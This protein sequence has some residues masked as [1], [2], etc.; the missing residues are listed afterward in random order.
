M[1]G[2]ITSTAGETQG[3][4]LTKFPLSTLQNLIQLALAVDVGVSKGRDCDLLL[5][6]TQISG[7]FVLLSGSMY[8]TFC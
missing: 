1:K 7:R 8:V 4:C 6:H 2:E 3:Y 5:G